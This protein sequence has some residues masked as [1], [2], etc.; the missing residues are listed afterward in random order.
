M[1]KFCGEFVK[2]IGKGG[3]MAL[4]PGV[5][6]TLVFEWINNTNVWVQGFQQGLGKNRVAR[7]GNSEKQG[8]GKREPVRRRDPSGCLPL[9]PCLG[10]M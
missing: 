7:M 9:L 6:Y 5:R 10:Y 3:R 4:I 2:K 8:T 1:G